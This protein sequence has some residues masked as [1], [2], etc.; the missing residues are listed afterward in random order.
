MEYDK[1][2]TLVDAEE[3]IR[4][5]D[6]LV[7][8]AVEALRADLLTGRL[9]PGERL[10]AGATAQRL[11]ISHIP[12]REA[13]RYLEAEGHVV[14]HG[15]N[16]LRI[17][18]L[19]TSEAKDIYLTR[20]LLETEANRLGIPRMTSA[21][22]QRLEQ[23]AARM[24]AAAAD[25][26]VMAYRRWNR[27]FHFVPFERAERPWITRFLSNLWDAAARYQSPLFSS[28]AWKTDHRLHHRTL[29]KALHARD[30]E[31]VNTIMDHH[32]TW[33]IAAATPTSTDDPEPLSHREDHAAT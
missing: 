26:D 33:L 4:P 1:R 17:A 5:P 14:R 18:P 15:R 3:A 23:L 25:A 19:T 22:D 8:Y 24:E 28:P 12:T 30:V 9:R 20:A 6:S 21:D 16:G 10:T 31:T 2:S 29:L 32:R 11:G 13:F 7:Q 27:A